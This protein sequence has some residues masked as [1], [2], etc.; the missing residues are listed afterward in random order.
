MNANG[1]EIGFPQWG[2]LSSHLKEFICMS[3]DKNCLAL[4]SVTCYTW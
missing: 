2:G 1:G 4:P 3:I